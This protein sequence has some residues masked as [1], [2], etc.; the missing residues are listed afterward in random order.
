MIKEIV[1][2]RDT[3]TSNIWTSLSKTLNALGSCTKNCHGWKDVWTAYKR[4]VQKYVDR[5]GTKNFDNL[6]RLTYEYI[7]RERSKNGLKNSVNSIP[8]VRKPIFILQINF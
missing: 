8:T 3:A 4:N 7:K 2:Q 5:N 6:Q 1:E